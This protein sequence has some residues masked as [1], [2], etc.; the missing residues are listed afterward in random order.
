L[1]LLHA[2]GWTESIGNSEIGSRFSE[3][4]TRY[5]ER[6]AVFPST[7]SMLGPKWSAQ[8][9]QYSCLIVIFFIPKHWNNFDALFGTPNVKVVEW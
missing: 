7:V 9:A 1:K 2:R 8:Q 6:A 3:R 5:S 4:D